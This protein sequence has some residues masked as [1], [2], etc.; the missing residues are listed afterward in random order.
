MPETKTMRG[1]DPDCLL[2]DCPHKVELSRSQDEVDMLEKKNKELNERLESIENLI[3]QGLTDFKG[4]ITEI[5]KDKFKPEEIE[6]I[7]KAVK[8][9]FDSQKITDIVNENLDLRKALRNTELKVAE[10]Q[11]A[12]IITT[13]QRDVLEI[14]IKSRE[15][16]DLELIKKLR[17]TSRETE[18]QIRVLDDNARKIR[19]QEQHLKMLEDFTGEA[20]NIIKGLKDEHEFLLKDNKTLKVENQFIGFVMAKNLTKEGKRAYT[21]IKRIKG[22]KTGSNGALNW[23]LRQKPELAYAKLKTLYF[24]LNSV[25]KQSL[26]QSYDEVA[27]LMGE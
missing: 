12:I 7:I 11:N 20:R 24:S 9:T 6:S 5:V 19:E 13:Q 25:E 4:L 17:N 16:K 10:L 14:S 2:Y 3:S 22:L 26:N 18:K 23:L 8:T 27:R 15:E 1:K 21:L